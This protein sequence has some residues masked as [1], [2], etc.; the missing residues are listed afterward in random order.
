MPQFGGWKGR[1]VSTDTTFAAKARAVWICRGCHHWN[2]ATF[3]P[4][5]KTDKPPHACEK[6]GRMD[7]DHFHS[8]GEAGRWVQLRRKEDAGRIK[9]LQTQFPVRLLACNIDTG[10]A[11]E[12]AV[13]Y[14]DFRYFDVDRGERILEEYKPAA[15]LT[16]ESQLKIRCAEAMGVPIEFSPTT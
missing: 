6:C 14:V 1:H 15:G 13:L 3:D 7:F 11:V 9:D 12:F 10:D 5:K 16:Y 4:V 8:G 2:R